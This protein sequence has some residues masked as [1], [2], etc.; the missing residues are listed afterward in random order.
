MTEDEQ[1]EQELVFRYNRDHRLKNAPESVQKHYSGEA[2]GPQK[3]LIR[4]FFSNRGTKL[5]FISIIILTAVVFSVYLLHPGYQV[6]GVPVSAEAF[7][8]D[9]TVYV[10]V[11]LAESKGQREGITPVSIT[12][13]ALDGEKNA[14]FSED[15]SGSYEG[16]RLT[17]RTSFP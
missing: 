5:L 13:H 6:G 4:I 10:T 16:K 2:Q 9:G 11:E 8:F 15:F 12:V 7:L 17:F 3:G 1:R 14:L